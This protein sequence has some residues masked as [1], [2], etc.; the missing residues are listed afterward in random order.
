MKNDTANGKGSS[1]KIMDRGTLKEF[2][3]C[4]QCKKIMVWR[5][6]WSNNWDTVKYCSKKC[7]SLSKKNS[8]V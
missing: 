8:A 2:K 6:K 5:K 1:A 4:G 3:Y 7:K